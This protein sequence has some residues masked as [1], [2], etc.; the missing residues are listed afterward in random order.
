M[1]VIR[2]NNGVIDITLNTLE[3]SLD[4]GGGNNDFAQR[5]N[6]GETPVLRN[7]VA[8]NGSCLVE[9]GDGTS[10]THTLA[11]IQSLHSPIGLGAYT[12]TIDGVIE[13]YLA[14]VDIFI[15]GTGLQLVKISWKGTLEDL[16]I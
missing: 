13:S 16:D 14:L 10:N 8:K 4:K 7:G 6:A 9:V 2:F 15:I 1:N 5:F 12:I 3:G 11:Q